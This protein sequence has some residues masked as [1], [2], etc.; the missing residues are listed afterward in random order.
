MKLKI[1]QPD[2]N[3]SAQVKQLPTKDVFVFTVKKYSKNYTFPV[4][5]LPLPQQ[6]QQ[7]FVASFLPPSDTNEYLYDTFI[8]NRRAQLEQAYVQ[9]VENFEGIEELDRYPPP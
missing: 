2:L 9:Y 6:P 5:I 4:K 1:R 7:E 8:T 3:L